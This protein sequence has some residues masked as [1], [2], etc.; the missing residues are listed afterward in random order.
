VSN[1]QFLFRAGSWL[2]FLTAALGLSLVYFYDPPTPVGSSVLRLFKWG[3][4]VGI[5]LGSSVYALY[6]RVSERDT[7]AAKLTSL[8]GI[9][10]VSVF[11]G[12][13]GA[14]LLDRSRIVDAAP[15]SCR[16]SR[17][18]SLRP[19]D[20]K[21]PG[22]RRSHRSSRPMRMLSRPAGSMDG[23][24]AKGIAST[25]SSNAVGWWNLGQSVHRRSLFEGA[26]RSFDPRR[27]RRYQRHLLAMV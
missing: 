26:R 8:L 16:S 17:S 7:Q 20:A 10:S 4:L 9:L 21:M 13:A 5:G 2:A 11:G 25:A 19:V 3:A 27:Y 23:G 12:A 22:S 24:Y 14:A 18:S 1:N 15:S 6:R